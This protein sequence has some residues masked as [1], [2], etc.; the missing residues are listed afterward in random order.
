MIAKD[1][2]TGVEL[3]R[4]AITELNSWMGGIGIN[5]NTGYN[6]WLEK[7]DVNKLLAQEVLDKLKGD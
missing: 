4:G 1:N 6:I 2:R 5:L 7:E 3:F